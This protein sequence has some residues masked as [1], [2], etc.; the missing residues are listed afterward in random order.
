MFLQYLW[1]I[2]D[3]ILYF[4]PLPGLSIESV[5]QVADLVSVVL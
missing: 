5:M 2:V 4:F 1:V 3:P